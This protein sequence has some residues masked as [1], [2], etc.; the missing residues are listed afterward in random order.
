MTRP[1]SFVMIF[2]MQINEWMN[3]SVREMYFL[4]LQGDNMDCVDADWVVKKWV[5]RFGNTESFAI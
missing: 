4:Y 2:R 5:E 3:E 1:I